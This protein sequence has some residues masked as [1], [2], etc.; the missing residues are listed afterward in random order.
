MQAAGDLRR[1]RREST[2]TVGWI[3][4]D[5]CH[6]SMDVDRRIRLPNYDGTYRRMVTTRCE[7]F[8]E[9]GLKEKPERRN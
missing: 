2:E 5:D 3:A 8:W 1:D 6:G 4:G 7:K 9:S